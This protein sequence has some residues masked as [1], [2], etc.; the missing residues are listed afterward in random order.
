VRVAVQKLSGVESV[1]VSLERAS[2]DIQLRRGNAITL[3]QLR[4]IIKNNGFTPKEATVTVV[5]KLI[6]R[7]GQ[8][9][10]DVTGTNTVMLIVADPKQPAIFKRV[11]D[12]FRGKPAPSVR[13]IGVV[14]SRADAPDRIAVQAVA[15]DTPECE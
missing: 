7:G 2:T 9:A 1:N 10:L 15:D 3:E 5:G 8:P 6:E 11:Q 14:E 13:L 4:S 12:R